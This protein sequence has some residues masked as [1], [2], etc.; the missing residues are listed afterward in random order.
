[1]VGLMDVLKILRYP[2]PRL[3]QISGPVDTITPELRQ[4]AEQMLH[5]MYASRGIGLSAPQVGR[6]IRYLCTDTRPPQNDE[7]HATPAQQDEQSAAARYDIASLTQ[8]EQAIPQPL[9]LFNP[10]ITKREGHTEFREGC[11]S[12]PNYY[13]MVA[14]YNYIEVEALNLQGHTVQLKTDG[15]LAIC[16]QHEIDHLDGKLFIDR[17]SRIQASRLKSKIKRRGYRDPLQA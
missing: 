3:Q 1:M 4:F 15:L 7:L 11:L 5:T 2:D 10:V 9:H 8:L 17:L 12:I 14:R 13:A 16:I 6:H